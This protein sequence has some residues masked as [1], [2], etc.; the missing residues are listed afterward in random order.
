MKNNY[1]QFENLPTR[2]P[3]TVS[4]KYTKQFEEWL[5]K[6]RKNGLLYVNIFYGDNFNKSTVNYE[7]FCEEF[8]K[9]KASPNISDEEVL[10]RYG[11]F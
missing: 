11:L 6:E 4:T 3:T 5:K 8:M 7:S 10:G 1:K 9:M 2:K